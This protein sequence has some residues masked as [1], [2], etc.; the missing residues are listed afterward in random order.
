MNR[1][2]FENHI[3]A[4]LEGDLN[5][6][7]I[8]EFE[9][10]IN[11]FPDCKEKHLSIKLLVSKIN[12]LPKVKARDSF[13]DELN[14]KIEKQSDKKK[15]IFSSLFSIDFNNLKPVPTMAFATVAIILVYSSIKLIDNDNLSYISPGQ[16]NADISE[17]D[18]DESTDIV[19]SLYNDDENIVPNPKI[20]LVK[21]KN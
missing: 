1:Y 21:G 10:I 14:M 6:K 4:Y 16:S 2:D 5:E 9:A 7:E 13:M 20:N 15:T 8:K 19:D 12:K 17:V 3:S 18:S 11:E